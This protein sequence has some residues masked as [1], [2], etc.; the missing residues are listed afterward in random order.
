MHV[1]D[2]AFYTA[3]AF[4]GSVG[5]GESYAEGD[6]TTDD[7][8]AL[9]R[10]L[11]RNRDVLDG[12]ERGLARL[13]GAAAARVALAA[14]ATRAPAAAATFAAHYDLGNDFFAAVPR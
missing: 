4:G 3:V 11:I 7:L 2:P 12:M 1:H 13:V 6:W 10:V 8:T 9:V 14:T 5:A